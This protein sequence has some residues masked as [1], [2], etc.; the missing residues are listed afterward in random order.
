MGIYMDLPLK[1]MEFIQET[2]EISAKQHEKREIIHET[3]GKT[4]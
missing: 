4:C 2:E 1:K 3:K